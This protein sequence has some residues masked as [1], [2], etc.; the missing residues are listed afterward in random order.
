[1]SAASGIEQTFKKL[2]FMKRDNP[3]TPRKPNTIPEQFK[4]LQQLRRKVEAAEIAAASRTRHSRDEVLAKG[5]M[6]NP[7]KPSQSTRKVHE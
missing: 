4:E 2:I 5:P 6:Q 1:L 7:K 3:K